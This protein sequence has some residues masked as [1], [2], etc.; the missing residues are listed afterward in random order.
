VARA[1]PR[2]AM[3]S[4]A[5][6]NS[7]GR[8][9]V[10]SWLVGGEVALSAVCLVVGGLLLHSLLKLTRVDVG[11]SA[12]R[13][14]AMDVTLPHARYPRDAERARFVAESLRQLRTVPGVQAAG[15]VNKLPLSGEG[16]NNLVA[17]EGTSWSPLD[18]PIADVRQVDADYFAVMG[19]PLRS[20]RHFAEAD[21]NSKVVLISALAA[22]RLWPGQDPI[23]RRLLLGP[24]GDETR[25]VVGVV[26]DVRSVSATKAP[27]LT[28]YV[29]YWQGL[30]GDL[31]LVARTDL[32]MEAVAGPLRDAVHR[33]DPETP[34]AALRPMD[35]LVRESLAAQRFQ[36]MLVLLFGLAASVLAALGI[37]G[38]ASYTV[39]QRTTELGIRMALGAR[40]RGIRALVLRQGLTPVAAGLMV[41]LLAA[42]AVGCVMESLLYEVSPADPLTAV[43]VVVTLTLVAAA[44]TWLPA[45]RATRVD[46]MV[47]LR[48]Q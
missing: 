31:S 1:D 14:V 24:T 13:V 47:T 46:P 30:R 26:A 4:A 44:G 3:Q 25:D 8:Q 19:I 2:E 15:V 43:A 27:M 18:R 29:P 5:R 16:G 40:P 9:G 7:G 42:G 37:Y 20:G 48:D 33:I 12:A 10:R 28:V 11:F 34:I 45:R 38:V 21:A 35:D 36:T 32:G 39:A 17:P 23:G 41:G 22:E 6:G